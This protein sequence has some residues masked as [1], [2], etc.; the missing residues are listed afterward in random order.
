MIYGKR[1]KSLRFLVPAISFV[2]VGLIG[3]EIYRQISAPS[4]APLCNAT[5]A[6]FPEF[7]SGSSSTITIRFKNNTRQ[8]MRI[9]GMTYC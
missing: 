7:V 6:S 3:S 4:P 8:P 5:F 1:P 9:I 2:V